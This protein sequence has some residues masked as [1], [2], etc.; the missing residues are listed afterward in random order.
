MTSLIAVFAVFSR[1]IRTAIRYPLG[2]ANTVLFTPLY[3]MVLPTLLLGAAFLV[4]GNASGLEQTAGTDDLPGW[5][6]LGMAVSAWIIGVIT[7][8][9]VDLQSGRATGTLEIQWTGGVRP[10]VLTF[11]S[12]LAGFALTTLASLLLLVLAVFL[13]GARFRLEGLP[14]ALLI[15]LVML[16]AVTGIALALAALILLIRRGDAVLDILGYVIAIFSGIAFP[17]VVLPGPLFAFSLVWPTTWGLDLLRHALIDSRTIFP[18]PTMWTFF[19]LESALA[20]IVGMFLFSRA[21]RV[22]RRH[23]TISQF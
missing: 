14:V 10:T 23:G 9:A 18:E 17:V 8:V 11:G 4:N 19:L 22:I 3:Q 15:S 2:L 16:V 5:L 12:A 21:V 1:N 20:F 13:L 7:T 6:M